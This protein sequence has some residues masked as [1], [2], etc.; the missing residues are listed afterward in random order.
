MSGADT[1]NAVRD[2][3]YYQDK[4]NPQAPFR[5]QLSSKCACRSFLRQSWGHPTT[6]PQAP[7]RP[8]ARP[9]H[10]VLAMIPGQTIRLDA[11]RTRPPDPFL[12]GGGDAFR[13][14]W[15][16]DGW[17]AP[18]KMFIPLASSLPCEEV[19]SLW[20]VLRSTVVISAEYLLR[21]VDRYGIRLRFLYIAAQIRRPGLEIRASSCMCSWGKFS[22]VDSTWVVVG[23]VDGRGGDDGTEVVPATGRNAVIGRDALG[24]PDTGALVSRDVQF[25]RSVLQLVACV[26]DLWGMVEVDWVVGG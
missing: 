10:Q 23:W 14:R 15:Q 4:P 9:R 12:R 11:G 2:H 24:C 18:F 21:S 25:G 20:L 17:L 6:K 3:S 1:G 8:S 7:R 16:L 19:V 13:S 22:C 26:G 5:I